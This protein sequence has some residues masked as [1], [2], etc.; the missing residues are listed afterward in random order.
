MYNF[1]KIHQIP[2]MGFK[3]QTFF[4]P[5]HLLYFCLK[6][7]DVMHHRVYTSYVRYRIQKCDNDT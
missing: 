5:L 6:Y 4:K 3:I 1:L 7:E 2:L